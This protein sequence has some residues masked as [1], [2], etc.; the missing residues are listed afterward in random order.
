MDVKLIYSNLLNLLNLKTVL[1]WI[2]L[3]SSKYIISDKLY[4]KIYF[5]LN[6]G[7]ELDFKNLRTF[8]QKIQILKLKNKDPKYTL[9]V[10]KYS[11]RELIKKE[12]GEEYLIPLIGVWDNFDDI[13]FD[14][15]PN[16]FILK[17]THYSGKVFICKDK[18]RFDIDAVRKK[19]NRILRRNYFYVGREFPYKNVQPRIIC[20]KYM[21]DESG[22]ELK[23]YKFFCFNGEPEVLFVASDR[24][25]D[26]KFDFYDMQLNR[27]PFTTGNHNFSKESITRIDSFGEM[28][29]I[30][31]KL[32]KNIPHIRIDLYNIKGKIYFG[33]FTFHHNGGVC[34]FHP[35]EWDEKLGD[36]IKIPLVE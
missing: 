14:L 9:M 19:I 27:L 21:V 5:R 28:I 7:E 35:K 24:F 31:R 30:A 15:L 32:S 20:E 18:S 2:L 6:M 3:R 25:G 26:V 33:E 4:L 17:P 34:P 13:D 12:L 16:Q 1:G 23:D 29:E 10:D 8:N 36:L 22:T 11:V